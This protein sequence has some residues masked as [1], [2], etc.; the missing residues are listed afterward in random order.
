MTVSYFSA[1]DVG[2]D[3]LELDCHLTSDQQVVV[4]HDNHLGRVAGIDT[5]ISETNYEVRGHKKK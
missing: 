1:L 2:F 5:L 4:A 3:M